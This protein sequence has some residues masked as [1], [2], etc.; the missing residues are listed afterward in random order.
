[1]IQKIKK[2]YDSVFKYAQNNLFLVGILGVFGYSI[3]YFIWKYLYPQ[4]YESLYLR[5]SCAALFIPWLFT[6]HLPKKLIRFFPA[7]FFF[8][9][10]VAIPLFFTYMLFANNFSDVWLMSYLVAMYL[11][12][13]LIYH[14][15][16]IILMFSLAIVINIFLHYFILTSPANLN[17]FDSKYIPIYLFAIV[18]GILC[19]RT[20]LKSQFKLKNM[21]SFGGGIAHEMRNP[22]NAINLLTARIKTL[23]LTNDSNVKKQ[24]EFNEIEEINK[25]LS[26]ILGCTSRAS[27]VIDMILAN[28]KEKSK[29]EKLEF[30]LT[31]DLLTSIIQEYGFDNEVQKERVILNTKEN[32][33][34]RANKTAFTYVIFNLLKNALYYLDSY[35]NQYVKIYF[36][37]GLSESDFNQVI[38]EDNGAGIPADKIKNLFEPFYT[39][40]KKEGTG[41]GL[42]FCKKTMESFDGTIECESEV[43]KFTKF[44]LNFPKISDAEIQKLLPNNNK[45]NFD[46]FSKNILIVE[47]KG[48]LENL[49]IFKDEM[50]NNLNI[51]ANFVSV[52]KDAVRELRSNYD[53]DLLLIDDENREIIVPDLIQIIRKFHAEIPILIYNANKDQKRI[54]ADLGVDE[55]ILKNHKTNIYIIRSIAKW[56]LINKLPQNISNSLDNQNK[57]KQVLIADDD[58]VNKLLLT[59]T[60][61]RLGFGVEV[62]SNGQELH[63]K[64]FDKN[65]IPDLIITDINMLIMN[66]DEVVRKIRK[67]G[68][69]NAEI[70]IIVYSGDSE[71]EK[72]H[73]F[74]RNGMSDFFIKGT[75]VA[76]LENLVKF[77]TN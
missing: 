72:I 13:L 55:V 45:T 38:V 68:Q 49:A 32:F 37:K 47:E 66:G 36:K 35:P 1:M 74:L 52:E 43:G 69:A 44:I 27:E 26:I 39:S 16:L 5:L 9:L 24:L 73:K 20:E 4:P 58:L 29:K 19:H 48:L 51:N 77:W 61:K 8:S 25:N 50:K 63:D 65:L 71:K 67:S 12:V 75:D 60:L 18:S 41:L 76:H 14:W 46:S 70:P 10:F 17:D 59:N 54:Y 22:L 2:E 28:L 64:F 31:S 34:I 40:G 7:Y 42:D 33:I 62:A 11:A 30:L 6:N 3:Y 15:W 21:K 56:N 53:Y 57:T 23:I